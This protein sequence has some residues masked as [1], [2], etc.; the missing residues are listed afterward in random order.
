[1]G[2]PTW[3]QVLTLPMPLADTPPAAPPA[4]PPGVYWQAA[5][6]LPPAQPV[7]VPV[8]TI[9]IALTAEQ[10]AVADGPKMGLVG[11][12]ALRPVTPGLRIGPSVFGAVSGDRGGFFGWGLSAAYR[13]RQ[14]AWSAEAGL[15]VGGG[16][17]SP[18]WVGSGLMLRPSLTLARDIG[19]LR[20]GLGLSQVHFASGTVRSAQPGASLSWTG[21]T[22]VGPAGGGPGWAT[23]S[24]SDRAW[25][26]E[27]AA[28]VGQYTLRAGSARRDG[29]GVGTP[30]RVAG[31]VVRRDLPG[32]AA[33]MR[34]YWLLSTA[35][36]LSAEYA[37]HAELLG[38]LG[39]RHALPFFPAMAVRAEAAVGSGGAGAALD[40]AG[41]L[42]GRLDLGLSWPFS[43]PWS[44]AAVAGVTASQGRF[45]ARQARLEL[46]WQG[47]DVV[48]GAARVPDAGA[49]DAPALT[50]QPWTAAAGWA[51]ITRMRRDGGGDAGLGLVL[52]KIEREIGPQ[53]RLVGRAGIAA[54]GAAGGYASGQLGVG[55]LGRALVDERWRFGAEATLG[56]AGGGGVVVGS[57]LIAQAQGVARYA[58]TPTWALQI[59]AGALRSRNGQGATPLLGLSSVVSF[60]RLQAP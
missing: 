13:W 40:T 57:G 20:L 59:D 44:V 58:V 33:G 14:G 17:G 41:G 51:Q 37:G 42:L 10:V 11:L 23:E 1:M 54:H 38:G 48:P 21:D 5:P 56:A 50:W 34:P 3:A 15:F 52:L 30:L 6:Q 49:G 12:H 26:Y 45:N 16:G 29:S 27:V 18:A 60:S 43:R 24:W 28:S 46:A 9:D 2:G 39:L 32:D 53:W 35:G 22:L 25:P 19:P 31:L 47:W 55:W 36:S 8:S 4:A 7:A